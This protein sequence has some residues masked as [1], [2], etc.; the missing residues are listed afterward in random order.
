MGRGSTFSFTLPT[1]D[2]IREHSPD[3]AKPA[4]TGTIG[5]TTPTGPDADED[6]WNTRL[7]GEAGRA[8]HV[9]A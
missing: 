9:P 3:G 8:P 5:M 6:V 1:V 4:T 2:A 7:S